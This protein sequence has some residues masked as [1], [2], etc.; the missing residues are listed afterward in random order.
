MAQ[1]TL[2]AARRLSERHMSEDTISENLEDFRQRLMLAKELAGRMLTE[3]PLDFKY[4]GCLYRATNSR[5]SVRIKTAA[6]WLVVGMRGDT[7]S[8]VLVTAWNHV[9]SV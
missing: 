2:H 5:I 1:T 7:K 8:P 6:A 3:K 4:C 9:P